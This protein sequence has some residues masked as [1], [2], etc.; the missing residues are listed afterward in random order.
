MNFY[1]FPVLKN[2]LQRIFFIISAKP[3]KGSTFS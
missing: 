2:I 1:V 3:Q